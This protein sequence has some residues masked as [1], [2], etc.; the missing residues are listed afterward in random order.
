MR[1]HDAGLRRIDADEFLH[2]RR[3][4]R[5]LVA[6]DR[7]EAL[8]AQRDEGVLDA[9][10]LLLGARRELGRQRPERLAPDMGVEQPLRRLLEAQPALLS[11][12]LRHSG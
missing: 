12:F 7:A 8:G 4:Q 9:V 2:L 1:Q 3:R 6:A 10:G 5:D 11:F